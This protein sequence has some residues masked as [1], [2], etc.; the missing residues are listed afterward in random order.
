VAAWPLPDP[1]G[2]KGTLAERAVLLDELLG[3]ARRRLETF[4]SLPFGALDRRTL[5]RRVAE[6]GE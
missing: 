5:A 6:I 2:Y 4:I 1:D 3:M